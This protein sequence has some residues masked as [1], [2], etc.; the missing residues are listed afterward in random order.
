LLFV[1]KGFLPGFIRLREKFEFNR[2]F[3]DI[4][5]G[6]GIGL[7]IDIDYF[8]LRLD[9][10]IPFRKSYLA[11]SKKWIFNNTDFFGD[12]IFSLAVGYP[13]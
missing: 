13:F 4:A 10:A 9:A 12:Y 2:F 5:V 6:G 1:I 7:R 8:V 3:N 11:D